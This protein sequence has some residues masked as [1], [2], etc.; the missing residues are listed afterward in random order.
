VSIA[1]RG[2]GKGSEMREGSKSDKQKFPDSK[3]DV[4]T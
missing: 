2:D 4:R 1:Y 3:E